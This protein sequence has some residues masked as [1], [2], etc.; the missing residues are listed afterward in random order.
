MPD[1]PTPLDL[2]A[3]EA[4]IAACR[5]YN[6]GTYQA[7]RLAHEHAPALVEEVKRLRAEVDR[8]DDARDEDSAVLSSLEDVYLQWLQDRKT[9]QG[10][11]DSG[12]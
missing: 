5:T 4:A 7:D 11:T 10:G 6:F 9:R 2:D 8:L 1:A 12:R 3:I